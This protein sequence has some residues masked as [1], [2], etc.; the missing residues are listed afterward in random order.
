MYKKY[1]HL[2]A[3]AQLSLMAAGKA[4]WSSGWQ[5]GIVGSIG[6]SEAISTPSISL[7]G[8]F[9]FSRTHGVPMLRYVMRVPLHVGTEDARR[10][11]EETPG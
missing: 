9:S 6:G 1:I 8:G 11:R 2:P 3:V 7:M 5:H 10:T 4:P